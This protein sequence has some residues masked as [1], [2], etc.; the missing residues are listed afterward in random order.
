MKQLDRLRTQH[1]IAQRQIDKIKGKRNLIDLYFA[2]GDNW[3]A[4][5]DSACL[6]NHRKHIERQSLSLAAQLLNSGWRMT[7]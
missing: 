3:W 6:E 5:S 4:S 1:R 7:V 2:E